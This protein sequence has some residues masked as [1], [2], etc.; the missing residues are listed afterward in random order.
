M[1]RT[2]GPVS[3]AGEVASSDYHHR[4]TSRCSP[5]KPHLGAQ[6]TIWMSRARA[7]IYEKPISDN[8]LNMNILLFFSTPT[9]PFLRVV[10]PLLFDAFPLLLRPQ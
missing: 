5:T 3:E 7:P 2:C 10:Y 8:A 4:I 9:C 1:Q 6:V